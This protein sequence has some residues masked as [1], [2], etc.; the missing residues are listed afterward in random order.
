MSRLSQAKPFDRPWHALRPFISP[1]ANL[2]ASLSSI[3]F[4]HP[5]TP[6]GVMGMTTQGVSEFVGYVFSILATEKE[7]R[8][9]SGQPWSEHANANLPP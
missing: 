3:I 9:P 4:A 7:K 6:H 8:L 5:L 1:A 2:V